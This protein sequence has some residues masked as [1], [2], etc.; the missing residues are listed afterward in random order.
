[1]YIFFLKI[2]ELVFLELDNNYEIVDEEIFVMVMLCKY[3][4]DFILNVVIFIFI[5]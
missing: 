5:I 3:L 1:M 4:K 2:K